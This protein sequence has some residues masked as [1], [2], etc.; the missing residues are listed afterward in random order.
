MTE[1]K[2]KIEFT[3]DDVINTTDNNL[4]M[5]N[6]TYDSIV[7]MNEKSIEKQIKKKVKEDEMENLKKEIKE[8]KEIMQIQMQVHKQEK[9][10]KP[11][12][13]NLDEDGFVDL[14]QNPRLHTSLDSPTGVVK[15]NLKIPIPT[16]VVIKELQSPPVETPK[17]ENKVKGVLF[18]VS[19]LIGIGLLAIISLVGITMLIH[20]TGLNWFLSGI[21][22]FSINAIVLITWYLLS[23]NPARKR[24]NAKSQTEFQDLE[25]SELKT[26]P[27]CDSR[28]HKSKV[29]NDGTG[30]TQYFKCKNIECDFQKKVQFPN[31]SVGY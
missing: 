1:D 29:I 23:R 13:E 15:G 18:A 6:E 25:Y 17:K 31:Q 4:L 27:K 19:K 28:L 20:F 22:S 8:L 30:I 24:L 10:P 9:Q 16:S 5:N 21:L 14:T 2:V 26:C 3:E 7:K 12:A 11:S